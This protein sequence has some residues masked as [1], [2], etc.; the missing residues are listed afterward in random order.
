MINIDCIRLL[1]DGVGVYNR[2]KHSGTQ[3]L[4]GW[5]SNIF[6]HESTTDCRDRILI[7]FKVFVKLE[8]YLSYLHLC[9]L[10]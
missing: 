8:K 10:Y 5:K 2:L 1:E 4:R 7:F 3:K 6:E 9:N